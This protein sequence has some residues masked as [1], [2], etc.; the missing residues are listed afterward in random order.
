MSTK[1]A[2]AR[3]NTLEK[4]AARQDRVG[5]VG[6]GYV[7]LP[8][9]LLYSENRFTVTGFDID[10]KKIDTLN[11]GGSYMVKLSATEVQAAQKHGFRATAIDNRQSAKADCLWDEAAQKLYVV[12]HL[13][14]TNGSSSS[15]SSNWGRLYRFSYSSGPKRTRWIQGFPVPVTTKRA[16][17]GRLSAYP[18]VFPQPAKRWF[19]KVNH[20]WIRS[21][22]DSSQ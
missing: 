8:L 20:G 12:S 17:K 16:G 15:S 14:T 22:I 7:G 5:I 18:L 1:A 10:Q 9:A 13:F 2:V 11:S 19:R 21:Q 6:M 3:S 4:I